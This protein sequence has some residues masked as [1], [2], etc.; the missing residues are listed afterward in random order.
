MTAPTTYLVAALAGLVTV[1]SG[2]ATPRDSRA[3]ELSPAL[4]A[5]PELAQWQSRLLDIGGSPSSPDPA[6]AEW[7]SALQWKSEPKRESAVGASAPRN[8]TQLR[9][10]HG[11][12]DPGNE[13]PYAIRQL[14]GSFDA[15][16]SARRPVRDP[17]GPRRGPSP[18]AR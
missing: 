16:E 5:P 1:C 18:I 10:T 2:A 3:G 8:A 12:I 17:A 15:P 14:S 11:A 13:A 7:E 4:N 9:A 6:S